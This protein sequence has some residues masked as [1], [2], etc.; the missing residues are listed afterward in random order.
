MRVGLD[1]VVRE[2][3]AWQRARLVR[4][5]S[6]LQ[7]NAVEHQVGRA[8]HRPIAAVAVS[9]ERVVDRRC[10]DQ[11]GPREARPT[12]GRSGKSQ[13]GPLVLVR[14]ER[15]ERDIDVAV[16][17]DGDIAALHRLDLLEREIAIGRLNVL[18]W[19]VDRLK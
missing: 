1:G 15:A 8:V 3:D 4:C 11:R 6:R 5:H 7:R 9:V 16:R 18:P 19:S 13:P 12:I 14:R 2:P 17:F 10:G